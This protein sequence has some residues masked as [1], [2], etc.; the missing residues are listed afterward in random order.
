MAISF[1][2]WF[3]QHI[4][5]KCLNW[6]DRSSE[7]VCFIYMWITASTL[8]SESSFLAHPFSLDIRNILPLTVSFF[9]CCCQYFWSYFETHPGC[10]TPDPWIQDLLWPRIQ[11]LLW[12]PTETTVN[13]LSL[14]GLLSLSLSFFLQWRKIN[15]LPSWSNCSWSHLLLLGNCDGVN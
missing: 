5:Q 9:N 6:W 3:K 2:S 13:L 12:P 8:I 15:F 10:R 11:D 14:Q 7:Y 1:W 4:D